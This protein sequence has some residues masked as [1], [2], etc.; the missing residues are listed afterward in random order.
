MT[1]T[2]TELFYNKKPAKALV[3]V[4]KEGR[5]YSG[6]LANDINTTDAHAL[7]IMAELDDKGLVNR[8]KEGRRKVATLT[9]EGQELA[10]ELA[11]SMDKMEELE[12]NI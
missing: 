10:E 6:Q 4:Y 3:N 1:K 5:T 2:L 11:D 7:G 8:K 12:G 9:K